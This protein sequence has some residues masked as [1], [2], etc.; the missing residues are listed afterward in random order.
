MRYFSEIN[1][2]SPDEAAAVES[3]LIISPLPAVRNFEEYLA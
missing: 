1:G 3:V 2:E